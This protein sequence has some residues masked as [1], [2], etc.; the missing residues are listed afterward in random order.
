MNKTLNLLPILQV[1]SLAA[2]DRAWKLLPGQVVSIEH[3]KGKRILCTAGHLWI[4]L[5]S[6]P[7]DY[8]LEPEQSL[9]IA[10]NG[11]IVISA[12]DSGDFKVA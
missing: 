7:S 1:Q 4:T 2:P 11:R 10:E 8:I 3:G 6:C 12:L 9:D 5:E